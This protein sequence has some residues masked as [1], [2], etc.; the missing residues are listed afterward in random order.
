MFPDIDFPFIGIILWLVFFLETGTLCQMAWR[1]ACFECIQSS[2]FL[3]ALPIYLDWQSVG[4][5]VLLHH[6][7]HWTSDPVF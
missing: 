1:V 3:K 6:Y 7:E 2:C 5:L 4:I